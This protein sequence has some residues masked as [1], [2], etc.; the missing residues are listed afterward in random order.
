MS[1][2][3][4]IG[5][6]LFIV[7]GIDSTYGQTPSPRL[8]SPK[9]ILIRYATAHVGNGEVIDN[10]YLTIEGDEIG[11][12]A[13]GNNV[14]IN[15]LDY[16]SIIDAEG[17]HIY[18]GFIVMDSRLGLNEIDAIAATH[19]FNE[20]GEYTP[21]VRTLP[22]FN[23]ES[24]V[25][26]TVRTNGVLMAQIAPT[27]GR[28][29]GS[30]SCVH[31]N[32]WNWQDATVEADEGTFVNWPSRYGYRGWWAEPGDAKMNKKYS[33]D[34]Q[35]LLAYFQDAKAY[36][37]QS[38][39]VVTNLAFESMR[40]IFE[41]S[42]R[43]YVRVDWAKDILDV[44]QF[45]KEMGIKQV[46]IVGGAEA[47]LVLTELKESNIAVII[48]RVHKLPVHPDDP[49]DQPFTLAKQLSEAGVVFAFA[50][51]GGMEHMISRN[52]PFEMGT[53]VHYGLDYENAIKAA[54]QTPAKLMGIDAKYG[55]LESGKKATLFISTGDALDLS[56]NQVE[57]IFIEGRSTSLKNHHQALF[58]KYAKKQA[59]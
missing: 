43:I 39:P 24:K 48:D 42:K 32:G 16:D 35:E 10:A 5:M 33:E 34:C 23:S 20:T 6:A 21:S 55:T 54:T 7:I 1:K 3:G 29:S 22:A 14:R 31:F 41:G 45:A 26:S 58:E 2:I 15:I 51:S 38:K 19:D 40:Q 25:I 12:L 30:S 46:A 59:H 18:P 27:G 13:N 56:T 9:K 4:I 17:K 37:K 11:I 36:S 47:H 53:A 50:M 28:V 52:L 57:A 8:K 49:L 44:V